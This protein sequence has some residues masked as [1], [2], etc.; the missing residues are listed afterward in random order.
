[1]KCLRTATIFDLKNF[2]QLKS[3]PA[4]LIAAI[5]LLFTTAVHAQTNALSDA[6]IQG[7]A[8]AQK[9]LE[10]LFEA[11]TGSKVA[12]TLQIHDS[13]GHREIPL[14]IFTAR[15]AEN[16]WPITWYLIDWTNRIEQFSFHPTT[17]QPNSFNYDTNITNFS[18]SAMSPHNVPTLYLSTT[19]N[20]IGNAAMIPFANSD[21]W[22]CDLGLEFFHW[23]EQKVL[24]KE[25]HRSRGCTVLES[26][27]PNP[28]T[29]GYSRVVSWIDNET[30]GIVEAYAYDAKGKKLKD[31]Y[32]KDFKK[33]DGQWQVQTLVMENVQTKSRS[34]LEFDVKNR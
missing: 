7:R 11:A 15:V 3:A 21:F 18:H 9:I 6:E 19:T 8:L 31:F 5:V 13:Q 24:K 25:V 4:C 32:P 30:L 20:L 17:N 28:G 23:P 2:L 14:T 33:V 12:A 29:N 26:T 1:M 27:N 34:V 10:Q 22:L 16:T